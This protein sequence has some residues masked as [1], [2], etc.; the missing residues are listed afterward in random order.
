VVALKNV[1]F[2][3]FALPQKP[4]F[5]VVDDDL[6]SGVAVTFVLYKPRQVVGGFVAD[7]DGCM[8]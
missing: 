6:G 7:R 4:L 2:D 5:C 1:F 8:P 3:K